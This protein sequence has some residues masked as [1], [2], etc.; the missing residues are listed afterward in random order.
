MD[1]GED[2]ERRPQSSPGEMLP[3]TAENGQ[4]EP[5]KDDGEQIMTTIG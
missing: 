3:S 4:G 2:T 5:D 1:D